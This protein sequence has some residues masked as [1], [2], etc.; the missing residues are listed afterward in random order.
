MNLAI[1]QRKER[2]VKYLESGKIANIKF[3]KKDGT[4]RSANV[5]LWKEA[6]LSS[7]DRNVV[8]ANTTA[9]KEEI[10]TMYD[11]SNDKWIKV[12]MN[13][14]IEFKAGGKEYA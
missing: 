9:H 14:V 6:A 1:K 4:E 5:R 7:G 12:N 3:V 10:V 2:I 13:N 8:Q 11:V